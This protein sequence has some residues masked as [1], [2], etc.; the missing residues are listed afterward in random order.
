MA[1]DDQAKAVTKLGELGTDIPGLNPDSVIENLIKKD[2]NLGK[3][4]NMIDSAKAEKIERGMTEEEAN[5]AAEESKKKIIDDLKK[6]IRPSVEDDI[7]T[8]KQEYKTAKEAL[9]SIPTE[10]SAT[11]ALIAI[12]PA[13]SAPPSAPNPAYTLGVAMQTKK[14]LLKTLNI[15]LSSLTVVIK[16]ASKLKFELPSTVLILVETLAVVTKGLSLIPG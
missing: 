2:E 15:V 9:D 10:V 14:S 12:P 8:M 4:L 11:A 1:L 13:I 3:Y 5:A 7:I 6:N 16:L